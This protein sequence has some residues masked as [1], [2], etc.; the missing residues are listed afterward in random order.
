MLTRGS[1]APDKTPTLPNVLP[2]WARRLQRGLDAA[3]LGW[4]SSG[5]PVAAPPAPSASHKSIKQRLRLQLK[6]V[7][8]QWEQRSLSVN[9]WDAAGQLSAQTRGHAH[10]L[11]QT[12]H[13]EPGPHPQLAARLPTVP[14][15]PELGLDSPQKRRPCQATSFQ[16]VRSSRAAG[17]SVWEDP[18]VR[19]MGGHWPGDNLRGTGAVQPPCWPC[20]WGQH[21]DPAASWPL[22]GLCPGEQMGGWPGRGRG[23]GSWRRG[24]L[25]R[26]CVHTKPGP[27]LPGQRSWEG[28]SRWGFLAPMVP[29]RRV[30]VSPHTEISYVVPPTPDT[31]LT[32][33][34]RAGLAEGPGGPVAGPKRA[35]PGDCPLSL[36]G[37]VFS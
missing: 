7:S 27:P 33:V 1:L 4:G 30:A 9:T 8:R 32:S 14:Q 12:R 5:P 28:G 37:G 6:R 19:E 3:C 23:I 21:I 36:L 11:G 35:R 15:N 20:P 25:S 18:S 31:F 13:M 22:S 26:R 24:S 16:R 34:C 10:Q 17:S 29:R 2:T